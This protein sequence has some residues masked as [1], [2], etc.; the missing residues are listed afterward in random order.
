MCGGVERRE[1]REG[2]CVKDHLRIRGYWLK[3][4]LEI[5]AEGYPSGQ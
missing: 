5:K 3:E 1:N 2:H 4:R